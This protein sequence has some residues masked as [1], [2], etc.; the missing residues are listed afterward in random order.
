MIVRS[1]L[2]PT[3]IPHLCSP[4]IMVAKVG[5]FTVINAYLK[6][7]SSNTR[8]CVEDRSMRSPIQCLGDVLTSANSLE[9]PIILMGDLNARTGT[10]S[11][12]LPFDTPARV[13]SD[14]TVN[15]RGRDLI[16]LA[17]EQ[18]LALL[19]GT[20]GYDRLSGRLTCFRPTGCSMVDY[21][22]VS[23][24]HLNAV[25]D[26]K[27]GVK[28]DTW[29]DHAPLTM[30]LNGPCP[31]RRIGG[32]RVRR[33][34]RRRPLL[35]RTVAPPQMDPG[36][37][38]GSPLDTVVQIITEVLQDTPAAATRLY[39]LCEED[40]RVPLVVYLAH[41]SGTNRGDSEPA[42]AYGAYWGPKC[43]K[44]AASLPEG[45]GTS[46]RALLTGLLRAL[47]QEKTF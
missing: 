36:C 8:E 5:D 32:D 35:P 21:A 40:P 31:H 2:K 41:V 20:V 45:A 10:L 4:D 11:P 29:T 7:E 37:A 25:D 46:K 26:F 24:T 34:G 44:N 47:H 22:F 28:T 27:I 38:N 43:P 39:G 3:M 17:S 18:S 1:D 33:L 15:A 23:A 14:S 9:R 30:L 19:N 13:S 42:Y 16:Q 12:D 6:P